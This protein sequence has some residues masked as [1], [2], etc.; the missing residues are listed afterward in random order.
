VS[1]LAG[2][3]VAA[4]SPRSNWALSAGATGGGI[5]RFFGRQGVEL[6]VQRDSRTWYVPARWTRSLSSPGGW[7]PFLGAEAGPTFYRN[8]GSDFQSTGVTAGLFAGLRRRLT[9]GLSLRVD[10]GP[11]VSNA[12]KEGE[13]ETLWDFVLNAD[14]QYRFAGPRRSR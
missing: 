11:F 4:D 8:P 3:T 7:S 13:S 2:A 1:L 9:A 10:I 12:R 6:R 5:E 14:V